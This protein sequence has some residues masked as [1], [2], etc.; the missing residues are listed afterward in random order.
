MTHPSIRPWC[1]GPTFPSDDVIAIF[2]RDPQPQIAYNQGDAASIQGHLADIMRGL[3]GKMDSLK[4]SPD[5]FRTWTDEDGYVTFY[6]V[7]LD[8][9]GPETRDRV[10]ILQRL[11]AF[12]FRTGAGPDEKKRLIEECFAPA[13]DKEDPRI[14]ATSRSRR[15]SQVWSPT[16]DTI[17]DFIVGRPAQAGRVLSDR[18]NPTNTEPLRLI[19]HPFKDVRSTELQPVADA[20]VIAFE[21]EAE[22]HI[23]PGVS[24]TLSNW[25]ADAGAVGGVEQVSLFE[26]LLLHELVELVAHEENPELPALHTHIV[27]T[28][29]ERYLKADLL[30]VAVEDFFLDWP[31]MSEAEE[32][33]RYEAQ[34][35]VELAEAEAMFAEEEIPESFDED[36]DHLPMDSDGKAP[37][38]KKK[39]VVVKK[40]VK[41]KAVKKV[42]K[43]KKG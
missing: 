19:S 39:K 29:F 15:L 20:R 31:V 17:L 7:L 4:R 38:K 25:D 16:R 32:S 27:A 36:D 18:L 30:S 33:E 14:V 41:K 11:G 6:N 10:Q 1:A 23:I 40:V 34:L 35:K 26:T 22:I 43:K 13:T 24:K 3:Y 2:D 9:A 28:T 8:F 12:K 42:V 37:V 5:E 21:R